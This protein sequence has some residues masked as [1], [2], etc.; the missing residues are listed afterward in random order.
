MISEESIKQLAKKYQTTE[1]NARREY[2]QHLFLY[3]FYRQKKSEKVYFKGGTA[4]RIIYQSPRFSEDLDFSSSISIR[5]IFVI[6]KMVVDA[7][8]EIEREGAETEIKETKKTSGGYLAEII[9]RAGSRTTSILLEIS[10]RRNE[11]R[12]ETAVIAGDFIPPY[13][14]EQ[15]AQNQLVEEKIK[16]LLSRKKPRDFFDLYFIL[17]A[18]L[19]PASERKVLSDVLNVLNSVNNKTSFNKELK[20]FLPQS[21]QSVIKNFPSVLERELKKF[22]G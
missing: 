6:E 4:L 7:L 5:N 16:A 2:F 9:F 15:L 12:G 13:T 18:N 17:R 21:H 10:L 11:K 14:V 22:L 8:A 19:L 3:H 20:Q 1:L